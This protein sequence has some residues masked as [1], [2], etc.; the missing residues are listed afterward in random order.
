M[1]TLPSCLPVCVL[2]CVCAGGKDESEADLLPCCVLLAALPQL[3]L[4]GCVLQILP[5]GK[6]RFE[7]K[8]SKNTKWIQTE[9]SIN[10]TP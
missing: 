8:G 6:G 10:E 1:E 2:V 9:R 4:A 7:N 3:L 5:R